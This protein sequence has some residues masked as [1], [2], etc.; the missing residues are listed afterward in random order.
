MLIDPNANN[1]QIL[2]TPSKVTPK[3][4]QQS[5]KTATVINNA[6]GTKLLIQCTTKAQKDYI[7][8]VLLANIVTKMMILMN[9]QQQ[10]QQQR[11]QEFLLQQQ[12]Q[13]Q[14]RK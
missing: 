7:C 8:D 13:R 6:F 12:Q 3:Q 4:Q 5:Q 11:Q 10:Q 14:K 2:K 9:Q 1:G